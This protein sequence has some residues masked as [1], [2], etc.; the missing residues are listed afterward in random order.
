MELSDDA[1]DRLV[2]QGYDP[3]YG[4][5]PLRRSIQRWIENPLAQDILSGKFVSGDNIVVDVEGDAL[6]FVAKQMVH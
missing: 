4:A 6:T 1:I 3:V 2:A 5:R